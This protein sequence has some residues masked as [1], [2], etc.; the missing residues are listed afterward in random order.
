MALF[1]VLLVGLTIAYVGLEGIAA[2]GYPEDR[3][4]RLET[5]HYWAYLAIFLVFLVNLVFKVVIYS[6]RRRNDFQAL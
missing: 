4:E 6:W 2:L 3:V 5:L 1:L